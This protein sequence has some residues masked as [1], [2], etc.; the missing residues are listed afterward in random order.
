M[1]GECEQVYQEPAAEQPAERAAAQE[2]VPEAP[3]AM[4][5]WMACRCWRRLERRSEEK[6]LPFTRRW[7]M[8]L[9][10]WSMHLIL[11]R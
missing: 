3:A 9:H 6:P 8:H 11:R 1:I 7:R 2:R 5:L 10:R 4:L